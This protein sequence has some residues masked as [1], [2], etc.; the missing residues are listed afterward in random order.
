[1]RIFDN[2]IYKFVAL[3]VAV[4]LWVSAQGV[5]D[6]EQSLDLRIAYT[7]LPPG[8]VVVEQSAAEVNVRVRASRA[9]LRR[10][11][12]DLTTY[13][14]SLAGVK[15]G[16]AQFPVQPENLPLPRGATITARAPS[17]LVFRT[18][19]V[20]SKVV[21]IRPDVAGELPEGYAL[22]SVRVTPG[23]VEVSGARTSVRRMR[24]VTTQRV[25]I[26][27]LRVTTTVDAPLLLVPN[28]WRADGDQA[29]VRV[30]VEIDGPVGGSGGR[31][32]RG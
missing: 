19:E 26:S 9:A 30:T 28:V 31:V 8:L 16:T 14:V 2:L 5:N 24:E 18:E 22:R 11:R 7:D 17:L 20:A 3:L 12:S 1:M 27:Q 10:M 32:S 15:E 29:P 13:V 23:Q 4:L 21:Q 6:I 25:D